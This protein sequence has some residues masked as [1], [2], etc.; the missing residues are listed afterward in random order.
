MNRRG[1][2]RL[3]EGEGMAREIKT[4]GFIGTGVMGSSMAGHLIEAGYSLRVY[5]RT[6]EKAESLLEQGAVW[7]DT[8]AEA[9]QGA[10]AIITM[11]GYP[12]DVEAVYLGEGGVVAAADEGAVLVDMTTSSPALAG[13]I[14]K[15]AAA[16]GIAS[17]DAPVSGGDVGARFGTLTI[18]VG[19]DEAALEAMRPVFE[20]MGETVLHHGGPGAGQHCKMA[21]QI[22]IA[23]SMLGLAECLEYAR[24]AKLDPARVIETLS[25]GSAASWTLANYG[26]RVLAGDFA[27]G[28]YVKHF[29]KD[30][31]IAL[32]E[33]EAMRADLPGTA[34]AK[35]LYEAL[36]AGGGS[37][38]GTQALCLLYMDAA[39]RTA[40]GVS[41]SATA[42]DAARP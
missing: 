1:I 19:G 20:A 32:A 28:F 6:R 31:R 22:A 12:S 42:A 33:A 9:A 34:L 40:H 7:C 17:L 23:A 37:D 25:G 24:E 14:A 5:N 36:A 16:R 13:R 3:P 30:L 35:R 41:V 4:I 29:I 2:R 21:N 27:P 18:M 15:A 11:V 26:P 8:P 10:D 38:L 39:D